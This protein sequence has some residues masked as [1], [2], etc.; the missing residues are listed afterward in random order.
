MSYNPQHSCLHPLS[1]SQPNFQ[2]NYSSKISCSLEFPDDS[3][4][5]KQE[6]AAECDINTI[7]SKYMYTGE[8]PNLN[9]RAPQ[10]L[11]C[12]D[13]PAYDYATAQNIIAQ[14]NTLFNELPSTIR[15]RFKNDPAAFLEFCSNEKNRDDLSEM[16]LLRPVSDWIVPIGNDAIT[17]SETSKSSNNTTSQP[18]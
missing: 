2:S 4:Y 18:E 8:I 3:P 12:S 1:T 6:F 5:T 9:E 10:Y 16:G 11:D 17:N 13:N 7:M 15:N 14:A